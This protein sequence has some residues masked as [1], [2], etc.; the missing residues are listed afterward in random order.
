MLNV[1]YVK[2]NIQNKILKIVITLLGNGLY[3]DKNG[4]IHSVHDIILLF[5]CHI[6]GISTT[7]VGSCQ[8]HITTNN[9]CC[10]RQIMYILSY[11]DSII[12]HIF[13]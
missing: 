13:G 4:I 7:T 11:I 10:A 3:G 8:N 1:I 6:L 2:L 5:I 12:T 9:L